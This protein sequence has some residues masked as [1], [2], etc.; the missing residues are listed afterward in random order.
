MYSGRYV[1]VSRRFYKYKDTISFW[2]LLDDNARNKSIKLP[3]SSA[4][5]QIV[6]TWMQNKNYPLVRLQV[7]GDD[8]VLKQV[9][10]RAQS[11][12]RAHAHEKTRHSFIVFVF[13]NFFFLTRAVPVRL[14]RTQ[15]HKRLG[16]TRHPDFG[17]GL[18]HDRLAGKQSGDQS[19][20]I[21][22]G[23]ERHVDIG[24]PRPNR[25]G[26]CVV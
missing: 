19:A 25:L 4:V 14:R 5:L 22:F 18:Q 2:T 20:R 15:A 23:V 9:N 10:D 7:D 16:D 1:S 24:Q 11:E 26:Q 3:E 17:R 8:L 13:Y 6:N 21:H 12:Y